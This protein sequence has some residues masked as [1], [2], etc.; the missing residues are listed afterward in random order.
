MD[1]RVRKSASHPMP[2][3]VAFVADMKSAF[4]EQEIDDA[5]RC[6][7]ADVLC[8]RKWPLSG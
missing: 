7:R 2:E 1:M 6:G 3:I 8:V 4:G 5:I